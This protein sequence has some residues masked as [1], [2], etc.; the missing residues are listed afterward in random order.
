V[1]WILPLKL[2]LA[3]ALV[4]LASM[5]GRRWGLK[6]GGAIAG[7][8]VVVGPTL[9]FFALEQGIP[10]AAQ[11]ALKA[12]WSL[13][14]FG[15]FCLVMSW[16]C[17]RMPLWVSLLLGWF[18]YVLVGWAGT[19][20][21]PSLALTLALALASAVGARLALPGAEPWEAAA[22]APRSYDMALRLGAT[23]ALLL[24]V[25]AAARA[26]GPAWSGILAAFPVASSIL[27]VFSHLSNGKSG[28]AQLFK[29]TLL[30]S[31]AYITFCG[32]LVLAL[33]AW[34]LAGGFGAATLAAVC[35]Q[36]GALFLSGRRN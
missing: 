27:G 2:T 13:L 35:V 4:G 18:A 36:I 28:P 15:A 8:P 5:A 33:P 19:Q 22:F 10:F 11:A 17:R 26:L 34:G 7:F 32:S 31:F 12:L 23:L 25:T 24:S 29:G 1:D 20:S 9:L 16:S 21:Q 14:P 6:V 3:P 30:G